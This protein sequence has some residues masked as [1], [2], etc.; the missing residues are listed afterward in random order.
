MII[1]DS[2]DK[3]EAE[4]A[5]GMARYVAN[6]ITQE[7]SRVVLSVLAIAN[8]DSVA[9]AFSERNRDK[10]LE[11]AQRTFNDL[12]PYGLQQ[13]QFNIPTADGMVT[14]LRVHNPSE[15]GEVN[16]T[17]RPT[18]VKCNIERALIQGLEQGKSGYGFRAVAPILFHDVYQGCVEFGSSFGAKFLEKL[19][20]NF[21]GSWA[22]INLS[23]SINTVG[24]DKVII[25][26][27]NETDDQARNEHLNIPE[28]AFAKIHS[29]QPHYMM[30]AS[31]Q[32]VSVYIPI[33]NFS[34]DVAIYIKHAYPTDYYAKIRHVL[35]SS[36]AICL[37]GLVLSSL[38]ILVL[39]R[40]I[41]VPVNGLVAETEKIKNFQLD[42]RVTVQ[43]HLKELQNLVSAIA[44]MKNGLNSFKKY[45]PAQLVR[46]LI[47]TNQEAQ[48]NGVRRELTVMFS[49][50]EDFT[51]ISEA[52]KPT[53]LATQ[54][55]M[56]LD[57]VTHII[58]DYKGTVDKYIGDSVM[59]FWG[60][61]IEIK[62]H[63]SAACVA[64]LRIQARIDELGKAWAA[65][66]RPILA[67][68]IGINTG[69][70]IVGNM[71]SEQ[72]LNYTVIGDTVNLASRLEGINKTYK[73]GIII[74]AATYDLAKDDIE[75]RI[76]D[77]TRVKGKSE[78]TTI[79]E[80]VAERGDISSVNKDFIHT[81]SAA[82]EQYRARNWDSAIKM[83]QALAKKRPDDYPTTMYLKRCQALRVA[84]PAEDWE[85]IAA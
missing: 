81:F 38:I 74:S 31:A 25:A 56:Y 10:L 66:G 7:A 2:L 20:G 4:R 85:G 46:Q 9:Q 84:P 5:N 58:M 29:D 33:K 76:L 77:F 57:A 8:N 50:I 80:L 43:A 52:L 82:V 24:G 61:P 12:K 59:A 64:A 18:V 39:Y 40:Q 51:S 35:I 53:E 71:G 37:L 75:A 28:V 83:F 16:S 73:T 21:P 19:N 65:Q 47:E 79:Y 26:A 54:L 3:R 45:V 17:Y 27:L 63:A 49:D 72:R 67:T 32:S 36:A 34:N 1:I 69:D 30:D 42:E 70:V 60:A 22:A 6:E 44:S 41:T 68:R 62:G 14:F 48:I 15:F 23:R 13:L 55:S 11:A 78:V